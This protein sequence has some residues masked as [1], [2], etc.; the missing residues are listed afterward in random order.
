V[1]LDFAMRAACSHDQW[2]PS[3]AEREAMRASA[4]GQWYPDKT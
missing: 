1:L 2:L 3:P 4:I